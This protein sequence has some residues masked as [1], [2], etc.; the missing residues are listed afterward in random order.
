MFFDSLLEK[1]KNIFQRSTTNCLTL[2]GITFSLFILFLAFGLLYQRDSLD[3]GA[4]PF[5]DNFLSALGK[6]GNLKHVNEK[7][8]NVNVF[9]VGK[10]FI[11]AMNPDTVLDLQQDTIDHLNFDRVEIFRGVNGTHALQNSLSSLP[12]YTKYQLLFGRSDHMQLSNENMLGCLLSHV[13]IW[14]GILPGETVAVIEEDAYIDH[15]SYE[16]LYILHQDL[17]GLPWDIV[18]LQTSQFIHTGTWSNIGKLGATCKTKSDNSLKRTEHN[19]TDSTFWDIYNHHKGGKQQETDDSDQSQYNNDTSTSDA[20]S[21]FHSFHKSQPSQH[22]DG[23]V[24]E[25]ASAGAHGYYA[26]EDE[27]NFC[28]WYGTRGYLITYRGAQLLLKQVYPIQI[29]IDSLISLVAGF[30]PDFHLYWTR[31]EIVHQKYYYISKLWD[32]C[33][34]CYIPQSFSFYLYLFGFIGLVSIIIVIQVY[35]YLQRF[36]FDLRAAT[37]P[38]LQKY[39]EKTE[40]QSQSV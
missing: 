1:K 24:G 13:A 6:Q 17:N 20:A 2:V 7:P 27:V 4:F 22:K 26:Y 14:E 25:T 29:Q 15:S 8:R 33:L 28:T 21:W 30:N 18:I 10:A 12:I 36:Q 3:I 32:A 19:R 38:S 9:G 39:N 37:L 16:R 34:K 23:V 11:I 31:E 40:C 5:A 35:L